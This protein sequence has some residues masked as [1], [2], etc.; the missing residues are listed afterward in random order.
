MDLQYKSCVFMNIKISVN[1]PSVRLVKVHFMFEYDIIYFQ[2]TFTDVTKR[3]KNA[4]KIT[5]MY[6]CPHIYNNH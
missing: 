1:F 3:N 4:I 2:I 6:I 5:G